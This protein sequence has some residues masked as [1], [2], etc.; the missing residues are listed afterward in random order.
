MF[1]I[2]PILITLSNWFWR[3]SGCCEENLVSISIQF[4]KCYWPGSVTSERQGCIF[5]LTC[6]HA[7]LTK[8]Y[9]L[10][11]AYVKF[12][13]TAMRNTIPKWQGA[14]SLFTWSHLRNEFF[15]CWSTEKLIEIYAWCHFGNFWQWTNKCMRYCCMKR[16]NFHIF[17]F[18]SKSGSERSI[19]NG[20]QVT[21]EGKNLLFRSKNSIFCLFLCIFSPFWTIIWPFWP[22]FNLI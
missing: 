1:L 5:R 12:F 17:T 7:E 9:V 10:T 11:S 20:Q 19:A 3:G 18:I 4:W 21:I 13:R 6:S 2:N 22:I 15:A 14:A 8:D 16:Y